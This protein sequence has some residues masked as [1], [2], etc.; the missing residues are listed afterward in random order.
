[1][2]AGGGSLDPKEC[3]AW[4][5]DSFRHSQSVSLL[6]PP[7]STKLSQNLQL[8]KPLIEVTRSLMGE[9][10]LMAVVCN[11]DLVKKMRF[12]QSHSAWNFQEM[13][14]TSYGTSLWIVLGVLTLDFLNLQV[15]LIL[16]DVGQ[17]QEVMSSW[18]KAEI[19]L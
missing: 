16:S 9:M 14:L 4:W 15:T 6:L 3:E 12:P 2:S 7:T 8:N 19:G 13:H 17:A 11:K 1:M 5:E 10:G 18:R